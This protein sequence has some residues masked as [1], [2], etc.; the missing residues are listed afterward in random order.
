MGISTLLV[1]VAADEIFL[2][3]TRYKA[4]LQIVGNPVQVGPD[5]KLYRFDE[6]RLSM[7]VYDDG[8]YRAEVFPLS[9][10]AGSV[11]HGHIQSHDENFDGHLGVPLR[12]ISRALERYM[13][14][15][16]DSSLH[17]INVCYESGLSKL[18]SRFWV[19]QDY[20]IDVT[21][22]EGHSEGMLI[23]VTAR[24]SRYVACNPI[25]LFQ[26]KVLCGHSTVFNEAKYVYDFFNSKEF[27]DMITS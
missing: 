14:S 4:N 2:T 11:S 24:K 1:K 5:S 22:S 15:T 21:V 27:Y 23:Y 25:P 26:L 18:P 6:D 13:H 10:N 7:V 3:S 12:D 9:P 19:Y 17:W 20:L 16:K 8:L